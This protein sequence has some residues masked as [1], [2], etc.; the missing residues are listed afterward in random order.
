MKLGVVLPQTEIGD[1]PQVLRDY[2][3]VAEGLGYDY[4]LCYDHVLGAN[5][6]RP[7]WRGTYPYTHESM[8][9]EPF[10]TYAWMAALTERIEFVTGIL[11]LPQRQTA[12]VAKQAA[13]LDRLSNGRV[14]LGI[15]V[16]W[17]AVEYEA[18]NED[19]TVRGRRSAEQVHVLRE[20]WTKPLVTFE[21]EFHTINDVGL[22]P[23]PVQQ[24]IPLWFGGGADVV[25]RRMARLGDGWMPNTMSVEKLEPVWETLQGY[26]QDAGR[27]PAEFGLDMRITIHRHPPA[28]WSDAV[29]RW[30]DFGATHLCINTMGNGLHSKDHISAITSFWETI[31]G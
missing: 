3:E 23:M 29:Q 28:T 1:D 7:N 25:L 17:N 20:L 6:D 14:R 5:P 12:L 19:F 18:L 26:V 21:G 4:V 16:G 11:I 9:H 13:Q 15:G 30:R 10:V 27:D 22:N 8:F 24:P 2:I 31:H